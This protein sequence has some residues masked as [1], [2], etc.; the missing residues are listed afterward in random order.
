[1]DVLAILLVVMLVITLGASATG[2]L[3]RIAWEI[4]V[5]LALTV[6]LLGISAAI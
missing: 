3:S 5:T 6:L 2:R 1:M 4:V